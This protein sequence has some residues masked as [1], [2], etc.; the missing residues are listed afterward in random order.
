MI[1]AQFLKHESLLL[2]SHAIIISFAFSKW[3]RKV[4]YKNGE[5]VH[6]HCKRYN[7]QYNVNLGITI[8][9]IRQNICKIV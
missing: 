8:I 6:M 3:G 1:I 9:K 5:N 4:Q 7:D 2:Y